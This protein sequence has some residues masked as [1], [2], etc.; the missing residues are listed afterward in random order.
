MET[1]KVS[2]N[3][4]ANA[5]GSVMCCIFTKLDNTPI[6]ELEFSDCLRQYA[7]LVD[8]KDLEPTTTTSN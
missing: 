2:V 7:D 3:L 5:D 1:S 4:A 8:A 6:T